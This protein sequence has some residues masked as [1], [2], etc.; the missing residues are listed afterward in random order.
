MLRSTISFGLL[1]MLLSTTRAD[2][3]PDPFA[4][5]PAGQ[6]SV[7]QLKNG[8]LVVSNVAGNRYTYRIAGAKVERVNFENKENPHARIWVVDGITL[9]S[10]PIPL[11]RDAKLGYAQEVLLNHQKYESDH[12]V[13]RGHKEVGS[14]RKWID[15]QD[16]PA[17]YWEMIPPQQQGRKGPSKAQFL[18][19]TNGR[20]VVLF[21]TAVLPGV[22]ESKA[23]QLLLNTAQSFHRYEEHATKMLIPSDAGTMLFNEE[24]ATR[25]DLKGPGAL[26][27]KPNEIIILARMTL[28]LDRRPWGYM[29]AIHDGKSGH[30]ITLQEYDP[31]RKR[32]LYSDTLGKRSFLL[33]GNNRADI[34][35]I[36]EK[37]RLFSVTDAELKSVLHCVMNVPFSTIRPYFAGA[38][39][40]G[41]FDQYRILKITDPKAAEIQQ[42]Y[43]I[44]AGQILADSKQD[45]RAVN[46][47]AACMGLYEK[48]A[49][50]TAGIAE[51]YG[52]LGRLQPAINFYSDAIKSLPQD[53]SVTPE[54]RTKFAAD[55]DAARK[56]LMAKLPKQ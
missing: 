25:N 10:V 22:D 1:T 55:W 12:F 47:Y 11:A 15:Y 24:L 46:M 41:A 34:K 50:A 38:S 18:N 35:A 13:K 45:A 53:A 48:S 7:Q 36:A 23:K 28:E 40:E 9:Q 17:L 42:N 51:V 54:Q 37:E 31:K 30:M 8:Y 29:T 32:F 5:A 49:R 4:K 52:R 26:A 43:L 21:S 56:Q 20:N 27:V 6:V 19:V 3:P 33:E 39:M 14:A 16:G 44:R 2:Q